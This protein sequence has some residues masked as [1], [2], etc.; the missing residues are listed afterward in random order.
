MYEEGIE[1]YYLNI[2][3]ESMFI[4]YE[5]LEWQGMEGRY[6]LDRVDARGDIT[7]MSVTFYVGSK[8]FYYSIVDG[9]ITRVLM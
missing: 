1:E 2:V 4:G 9:V 3:F 7:C 8:V 6:G 5:A